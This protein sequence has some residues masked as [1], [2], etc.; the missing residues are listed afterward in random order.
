[1]KE[2]FGWHWEEF[3][4]ELTKVSPLRPSESGAPAQ[5]RGVGAAAAGVAGVPP[6]RPGGRVVEVAETPVSL[7]KVGLG[8]SGKWQDHLICKMRNSKFL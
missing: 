6:G 7:V 3:S 5:D 1:M 2:D 8:E 4:C